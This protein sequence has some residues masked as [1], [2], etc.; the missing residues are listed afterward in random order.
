MP[1]EINKHFEVEEVLN[2]Q[3]QQV[4]EIHKVNIN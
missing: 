2:I 3:Q 4:K 1:Q